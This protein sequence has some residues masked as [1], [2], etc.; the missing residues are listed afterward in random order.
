VSFVRG[1]RWWPLA[2]VL[3]LAGTLASRF[4][5]QAPPPGPVNLPGEPQVLTF[6][7]QSIAWYQR[8]AGEQQL[9]NGSAESSF[10]QENRRLALEVLRLSFDFARADADALAKSKIAAGGAAPQGTARSLADLADQADQQVQQ[11]Q[12]ELDSLQTSLGAATG[13]RR[14]ALQSAVAEEESKLKLAQTRRDVIRNMAEFVSTGNGAAG[15][16]AGLRGQIDELEKTVPAVSSKETEPA[17]NAGAGGPNFPQPEAVTSPAATGNLLGLISGVTAL[18]GKAGA[19]N[20]DIRATQDFAR[21]AQQ[22]RAPLGAGLKAIVEQGNT[23]ANQPDSADAAVLARQKSEVDALTARFKLL[24]AV[25]LPL[26][27]QNVLLELYGR[28][29]AGWHAAVKRQCLAELKSLILRLACLALALA[30]LLVASEVWRKTIFRYVQDSR[31][32]HQ[33]LLLRRIVCWGAAAIILV[34]A[35]ATELG[36]LAT[37]AG[38]MTAGIALALQS[39]I[40]AAVG[41]LFLIGKYGVR[42]GDRVQIAGIHGEVVEIGLVRLHVMEL[43]SGAADAEPTGRVVAFS[44]AV[45]FQPGGG[46]FR[47]IPGASLVWHEMALAFAPESGYRAVEERLK[48][49]VEKA[50]EE[51]RQE[52]EKQRRRIE[53]ALGSVAIRTLEPHIRLQ[54]TPAELEVV[55][56][57][58][59]ETG[60]AAMVDDR[61][62][63]ELHEAIEGVPKLKLLRSSTTSMPPG[64][65]G[66]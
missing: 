34:F 41:Y 54:L 52:M 63:R 55:I 27:K 60:T 14:N 21:S 38:L 12:K 16:A 51:Y 46:I 44:N 18:A 64:T 59:A 9:A 58:P 23:I 33:L 66:K 8:A 26:A 45:V 5:A 31:R 61:I 62:A 39:V 3:L 19:L 6:L 22:L 13:K 47:Q 1:R 24:T 36:S 30:A 48:K 2:A 65:N 25:F 42:I 53:R 43:N 11:V 40:L 35:F 50:Y 7:N 17:N 37:F 29:L 49:A 57:Y 4:F 32:R 10:V 28:E 15:A 20:E 56:R